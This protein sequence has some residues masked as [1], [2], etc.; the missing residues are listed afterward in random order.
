MTAKNSAS[1]PVSE[2]ESMSGLLPEGIKDVVW[3]TDLNGKVNYISRSVTEHTGHLPEEYYALTLDQILSPASSALVWATIKDQL[4]G[5]PEKRTESVTLE[6][7]QNTKTGA[8]IDIEVT[9]SWINDIAGKPSGFVG[10]TRNITARKRAEQALRESEQ[11]FRDLVSLASE[12]ILIHEDGIIIN[13]NQVAAQMA[14]YPN[15]EAMI[16][17]HCLND[18]PYTPD[19]KRILGQFR[20]CDP[21]E[22]LDVEIQRPDGTRLRTLIHGRATTLRGRAVRIVSLLDI[23]ER[24]AAETALRDSEAKFRALRT[25]APDGIILIDP[26][27]YVEYWNPAVERLLGQSISETQAR[28]TLS[29]ILPVGSGNSFEAAY[30]EFRNA[31]ATN[32]ASKVTELTM[33]RPDGTEFPIEITFYPILIEERQ[34]TSLIIRDISDRKHTE[35]DRALNAQRLATLV[36]LNQMSTAS[37]NDLVYFAM[38]E[39]IKLTGSTIGYIAFASEDEMELTT[40]AWSKGAMTE[41]NVANKSSKC[42][43]NATGLWGEAVRQR[44]PIV[45]N[46]YSE[47]NP[48]KKGLPE[49]HV[50]IFRHMNVP[51]FDGNRIVIVAGVGNKPSNYDDGDVRQLTLLME[52]M[53]RILTRRKSEEER[54]SLQ[55]QLSQASKMEA[56]GRLA[57]GVAHDFN[58]LLTTILGYSEMILSQLNE[59]DAFRTEVEEIHRAGEHA[60]N[61]TQQ[62]LAFSRKQVIKPRIIDPNE[63]VKNGKK[64]LERLIGDNIN[65]KFSLKPDIGRIKVDPHQI[66]QVLLNLVVNARD[67]MPNGGTLTISTGDAAFEKDAAQPHPEIAAGSYV[68]LSVADTGMGMNEET[69]AR[70]FEPF[71]STKEDSKGAGLGLAMVYGIAKQNSGA[72]TVHSEPGAGTVFKLYLPRTDEKPIAR[73]IPLRI[74]S[75]TGSETVLL[76]EDDEM[77]RRLSQRVLTHLGYEVIQA[78]DIKDA[79]RICR[80]HPA[81]IHLL[82]TDV[83]MP[84]MNGVDL[85]TLL[86]AKRTDMKA[87]FMS[88][89]AEDVVVRQGVIPEGTE[90]I[91][92][93]FNMEDLANRVRQ[94]IDNYGTQLRGGGRIKGLEE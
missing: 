72:V 69:K 37:V 48:L 58:N 50:P 53:W 54:T 2:I 65:L 26:E 68:V 24:H 20:A 6:L 4:N 45:T 21:P 77:V 31:S 49:G 35:A 62:L 17:K 14:G 85:Y 19:S 64:M 60:A 18:I 81:P 82:L 55:N 29:A 39:G 73:V 7:Q 76:V 59:E 28:M 46:S 63:A 88:G 44:R 41:C 5:P 47:D 91:Q 13:A 89:Y 43:V 79:I 10:I 22:S 84:E 3:T 71:F 61:L 67:A 90:F 30:S 1:P 42:P 32:A 27:S 94:V 56:I 16:G 87:L 92:K 38:E 25:A 34:W 52:G 75:P 66:D 57:G 74:A 70:L 8:L 40:Y 23:T 11:R 12:G 51:V 80:E 78:N 83:I 9:V 86:K 36:D 15:P 93:P 33:V